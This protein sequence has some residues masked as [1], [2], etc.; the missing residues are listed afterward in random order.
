M[1]SSNISNDQ[2]SVPNHVMR[3][4]WSQ[5]PERQSL[6]RVSVWKQNISR[7]STGPQQIFWEK[8]IIAE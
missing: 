7:T 6:V 5:D 1:Y 8:Y 2:F 4:P 3:S